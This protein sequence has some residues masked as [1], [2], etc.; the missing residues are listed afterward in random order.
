MAITTGHG[1]DLEY[2]AVDTSS[3]YG[4]PS[5]GTLQIPSDSI[6]SVELTGSN[7]GEILFSTNDYDGIDTVTGLEEYTLTFEYVLQRHEDTGSG[8]TLANSIEYNAVNR[9]NGQPAKLCF[10]Y[11]TNGDAFEIRGAVCNSFSISGRAGEKIICRAEYYATDV[12]PADSTSG[13]TNYDSLTASDT[14]GNTYEKFTGVAVSRSGSWAAGVNNF[15]FE[16]VN[17]AER[18]YTVGSATA[19][20][21][22]CGKQE[23][24]GSVDILLN[25]GGMDDWNEMADATEQNI[26][27]ASGNSTAS[28]D[29]SM[30]WTFTN[31]L[32]TNFPLAYK[33]DDAYIVSGVDWIAETVSLAAYS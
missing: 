18:V 10:V 32:Y 1:G 6:I 27:F 19:S 24:R 2:I 12:V 15:S 7:G 33:A 21:I 23:I 25:D 29:V 22:V 3:P 28:G 5:S 16:I 26:V 11:E 20:D 14:I 9:S 31:A 13:L 17:N 4:L 30:K 8:H